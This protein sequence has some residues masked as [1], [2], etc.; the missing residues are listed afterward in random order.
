MTDE[1]KVA[2]YVSYGYPFRTE[3]RSEGNEIRVT[4][5]PLYKFDVQVV[6]N[7]FVIFLG[8]RIENDNN[9]TNT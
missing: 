4:I 3:S 5:I 1:D 8:P 2:V 6:E 9:I 7:Q